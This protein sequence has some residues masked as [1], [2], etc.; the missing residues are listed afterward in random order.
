[1]IH[2]KTS[3]HASAAQTLI[4]QSI[5][6]DN[7]VCI[8]TRRSG[9]VWVEQIARAHAAGF[10]FLSLNIGDSEIEL[11]TVIRLAADFRAFVRANSDKYLMATTAADIH[12]AKATGRTAIAFD[13]EGVY[14]LDGQISL[15]PFLYEI[16]V[17]WMLM[18]Y[19]KA[20]WAAGGCHDETDR[21]LTLE[22]RKLVKEMDRVGLIKCCSH[23]G[24]RTAR[25]VLEMTE[26]PVV[27]SHS[28]ARALKDH[29]RNIPDDLIKACAATGGVIGLNGLNIFL[30]EGPNLIELLADHID[31]M[32]ELVGTDHIGLGLDYVYDMDDLNQQLAT[33][34]TVWPAGFGYGPGIKFVPPEQLSD[35]VETLLQRGYGERDLANILGGNF[36][37]LAETTWGAR[38]A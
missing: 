8:T 10:S 9:S 27:F 36:L 16:G 11:D 21:G 20:N 4:D 18:A 28:N 29:P 7:H 34:E 33:A 3:R 26:R 19:N 32:A 17:R 14:A 1:M 31:H 35:L 13:L 37:R 5:V 2:A 6:W 12:A 22:G 23:T 38:H 25:D 30:G 15:V 24:Y